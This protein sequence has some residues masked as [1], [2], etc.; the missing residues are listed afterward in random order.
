M[1]ELTNIKIM[2][3]IELP[4][5]SVRTKVKT[6]DLSR[7]VEDTF[8]ELSNYISELSEYPTYAP[9]IKFEDY[10]KM[11]VDT[12]HVEI[13][14]PVS[15]N[16]PERGNIHST[17]IP[18]SKVVSCMFNGDFEQLNDLYFKMTRRFKEDDYDPKGPAYLFIYNVEN[19]LALLLARI[20]IPI[21]HHR[22]YIDMYY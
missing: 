6:N 11:Y 19:S 1:P 20:V 9:F 15:K 13:G 22:K 5:L 4:C 10:Q 16:L 18:E 2:K 12:I 3:Q 14:F 21:K 17:I 7:V 8:K